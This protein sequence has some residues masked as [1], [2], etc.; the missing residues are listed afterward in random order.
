MGQRRADD[1]IVSEGLGVPMYTSVAEMF[2]TEHLD[3]VVI[4]VPTH[5]HLPVVVECLEAAQHQW[6]QLG[7]P[8]ERRL[9]A[10]L[11]EKPICEDLGAAIQL[12]YACKNAGVELL[13]GHQRRHSA[14]VQRARDVVQN[15][16]FGPLRGLTMEFALLKPSSYFSEKNGPKLAWRSEK[17][18][19]GPLL[20]NMIHDVD[21][22]RY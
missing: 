2:R 15:A 17:G 10:V 3:G 7:K 8:S 4:A 13:I 5:M 18:K 12:V 22:L 9:R 11:V 21:L 6:E 20:I 19:G 1:T 14:F 16:F